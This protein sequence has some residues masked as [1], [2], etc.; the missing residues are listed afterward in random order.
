MGPPPPTT[1]AN[2]A[3]PLPRRSVREAAR[4]RRAACLLLMRT[5]DLARGAAQDTIMVIS[6]ALAQV[7]DMHPRYPKRVRARVDISLPHMHLLTCNARAQTQMLYHLLRA[8]R[9]LDHLRFAPILP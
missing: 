9:T 6:P 2:P 3:R 4:H 8:C 7:A 1:M 5:H